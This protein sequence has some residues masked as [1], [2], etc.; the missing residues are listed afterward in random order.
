MISSMTGKSSFCTI[1]HNFSR[2]FKIKK[3][4]KVLLKSGVDL[5]LIHLVGIFLSVIINDRLIYKPGRD[6]ALNIIKKEHV[7][8]NR[9]NYR[10]SEQEFPI[11]SNKIPRNLIEHLDE[12]NLTTLT[13]KRGVGGFNVIHP[14]SD[15]DMVASIKSNR[16]LYPYNLDLVERKVLFFNAQEKD[17]S[18][19]QFDIDIN[20]LKSEL[21][22]LGNNVKALDDLLPIH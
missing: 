17:P 8:L 6:A 13:R 15:P 16:N 19:K 4:Q 20:E 14:D 22:K 3:W 2:G 5:S 21:I 18:L 12:R 10:F 7:N 11:I 9:N 1:S